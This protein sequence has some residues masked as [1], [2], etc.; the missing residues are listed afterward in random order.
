MKNKQR[1]IIIVG[2]SNRNC[3]DRAREHHSKL[4]SENPIVRYADEYDIEDNYSL[5]RN[6]GIII[7]EVNLKP[8]SDLIIKTILEYRGNVVLTSSNQKDVPK[9]IFKLVKLTRATSDSEDILNIRKISPRSNPPKEYDLDIFKIMMEY[10]KN[11]DREDVLEILKLNKPSDTQLLSWLAQNVHPNKLM[12]IDSEVKR[13]WSSDYFYEL[14]AYSHEGRTHGKLVMPKRSP[15]NEMSDICRRLKL[16]RE[17]QHLLKHLLEDDDF[18]KYAKSRLDNRQCRLLK[19][20]EKREI[21]IKQP[22]VVATKLDKW[23]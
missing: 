22:T 21:K 11:P 16:K 18:R 20:G 19:L 3:I 8:K 14:L 5:P 1:P 6:R 9:S 2:K 15:I 12:Y 17:Q 13:K 7:R 10:L 23:L 4:G